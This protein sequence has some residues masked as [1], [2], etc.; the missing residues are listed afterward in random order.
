LRY[1]HIHG[2]DNTRLQRKP[3]ARYTYDYC[4]IAQ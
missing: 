2:V 1:F 4:A 3:D